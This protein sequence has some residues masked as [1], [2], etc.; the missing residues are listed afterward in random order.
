MLEIDG[1]QGEGGGQILRSSVALATV[2]ST[3]IR[4]FN[5][6]AGRKKPGL[7][8]QHLTAMRAAAKVCDAELVGADIGA[9]E[10]TFTPGKI[11]GGE[12]TFRVGTAG[13]TS[14]VFQTILPA[15]LVAD[16]PSKV[17]LQGGTHN[18]SAPPYPFLKQA[19]LPLLNRM[20][21]S[22]TSKLN[23]HGFY[24]AGGGEVE[25]SIEPCPKL[26]SLQLMERGEIKS[27]RVRAIC[28]L[29]PGSVGERECRVIKRKTGWDDECFRIEPVTESNGPGNIV[30]AEIEMPNI[31]EVF[32]SFGKVGRPAEAVGKDVAREIQRYL[33]HD[34]PVGEYLA[35]Q[36]LLPMAI[37]KAAGS[38][39][40]QFRT[41][42][43]SRHATTHIDI[44]KRFLDVEINV[45]VAERHSV[46][47]AI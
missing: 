30:V 3:P 1:S 19:Y 36:L 23:R 33:A 17:T 21:A 14:L 41:M 15:L 42:S 5:I 25:V 9:K 47:V 31:T 12:Y 43:L 35:D 37:G 8:R 18:P 20:G 46:T 6:R 24:P 45:E 10:L 11:R 13:S 40:G 29:I 7:M 4:V 38:G 32:T 28:A 44:I 34:V 22:V 27:R 26:G 39:G 2:S 16:E